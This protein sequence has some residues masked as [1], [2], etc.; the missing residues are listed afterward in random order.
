[1]VS[2]SQVRDSL[3]ISVN[4]GDAPVDLILRAKCKFNLQNMFLFGFN[5]ASQ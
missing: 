5:A 3:I 1:M 4:V 2:I